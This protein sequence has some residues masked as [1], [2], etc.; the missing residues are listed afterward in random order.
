MGYVYSNELPTPQIT[1]RV[2]IRLDERELAAV[3]CP[4]VE[5]EFEFVIP[6]D[7][8]PGGHELVLVTP[9]LI[10]TKFDIQIVE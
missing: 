4:E 8:S 5:C 1:L 9:W 2:V 3:D 7:A 10:E 6:A